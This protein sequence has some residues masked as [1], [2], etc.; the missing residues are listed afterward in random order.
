V[1]CPG[2]SVR[3]LWTNDDVSAIRLAGQIKSTNIFTALGLHELKYGIDYEVNQ[4]DEKVWYSGLNGARGLSRSRPEPSSCSRCIHSIRPAIKI[5]VQAK[6]R[7]LQQ[8]RIHS[9]KLYALVQPDRECWV[10]LGGAALTDYM[11]NTALSIT[12]SFAPRIGVVYDPTKEGRSKIFAHY[13]QYYES[14]PMDLANRSF[15]GKGAS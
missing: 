10:A 12:D 4:Y 15:G 3:W 2:I 7:A 14:I 8:W 9:R 13:G 6:N 11:G 5:R 1:S